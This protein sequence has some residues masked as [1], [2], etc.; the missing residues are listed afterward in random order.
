MKPLGAMDSVWG[1]PD[2]SS[3]SQWAEL[4][5]RA[6]PEVALGQRTFFTQDQLA[7]TA[8]LKGEYKSL[9]SSLQGELTAKSHFS[10]SEELPKG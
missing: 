2:L 3:G 1:C 8:C 5:G 6:G 4:S 10:S 7:S 9:A